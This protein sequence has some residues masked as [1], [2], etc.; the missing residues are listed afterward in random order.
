[1]E[2]KMRTGRQSLCQPCP[3]SPQPTCDISLDGL[4]FASFPAPP[5][6]SRKK[7]NKEI[8]CYGRQ[9]FPEKTPHPCTRDKAEA[10]QSRASMTQRQQVPKAKTS[11]GVSGNEGAGSC[12]SILC[13]LMFP[14]RPLLS[15]KPVS[16]YKTTG[17]KSFSK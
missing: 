12:N 15:G 14:G 9:C 11:T 2:G 1:M 6:V 3:L 8:P 10:N 16:P 7:G 13:L 17:P 4:Q 5:Y